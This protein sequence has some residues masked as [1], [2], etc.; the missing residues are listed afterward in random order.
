MSRENQLCPKI[1][2]R[3]KHYEETKLT[4]KETRA[5][6]EFSRDVRQ[7]RNNFKFGETKSKIPF[8][9]QAAVYGNF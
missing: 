4:C 5:K 6:L 2:V 8:I 7:K 1:D 9:I 3:N